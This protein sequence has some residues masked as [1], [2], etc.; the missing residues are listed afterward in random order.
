MGRWF[1]DWHIRFYGTGLFIKDIYIKAK[2]RE[3]AL[4][5]LHESGEYVNEVICCRRIDTW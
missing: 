3:D 1:Y 5:R 4:K 2:S